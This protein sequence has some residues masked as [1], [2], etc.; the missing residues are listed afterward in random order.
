MSK[1]TVLIVGAVALVA[2]VLMNRQQQQ[3]SGGGGGGRTIW[4]FF[5]LGREGQDPYLSTG[6]YDQPDPV[7]AMSLTARDFERSNRD[8]VPACRAC[9]GAAPR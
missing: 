1:E 5:G 4:D 2:I 7:A 9:A 8:R 3:P 6:E